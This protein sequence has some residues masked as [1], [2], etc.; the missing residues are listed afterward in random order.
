MFS[1]AQLQQISDRAKV[2]QNS[3]QRSISTF[4]DDIANAKDPSDVAIALAHE[5]SQGGA[6]NDLDFIA[7]DPKDARKYVPLPGTI[8][9]A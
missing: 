2:K 9:Q 4:V 1:N 5:W 7:R 8:G 3:D 6:A